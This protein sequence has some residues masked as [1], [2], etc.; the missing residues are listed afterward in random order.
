MGEKLRIISFFKFYIVLIS[1]LFLGL[2]LCNFDL[3]REILLF[4][5]VSLASPLAFRETIKFRGVRKGDM[6]LISFESSHP[7]GIFMQKLPARALSNG[8]IGDVI[9]VEYSSKTAH[10]EVI[11]YGG[12]FFPPEVNILYYEESILEEKA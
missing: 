5:A 12:L 7:I 3:M 8:R 4:L 6:V 9:E 11:N 2:S 10:G 1:L